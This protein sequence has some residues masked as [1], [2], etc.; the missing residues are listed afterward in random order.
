MGNST[1]K[2]LLAAIATGMLCSIVL[3]A[4]AQYSNEERYRDWRQRSEANERERSNREAARQAEAQRER[5]EREARRMAEER[6]R[7][8]ERRRNEDAS[9]RRGLNTGRGPVY[10]GPTYNETTF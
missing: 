2:T 7:A 6:R 10:Q 3:P 5:E 9:Q 4:A 8:D 1:M